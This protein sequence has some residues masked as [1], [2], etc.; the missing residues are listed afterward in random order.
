MDFSQMSTGDRIQLF[1]SPKR[2][3]VSGVLSF[4]IF[5]EWLN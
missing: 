1:L 4:S 3:L 2:L 5:K